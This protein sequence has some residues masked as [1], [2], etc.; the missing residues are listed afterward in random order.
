MIEL[1]YFGGKFLINHK[2]ISVV[3]PLSTGSSQIVLLSGLIYEVS[4]SLSNVND[5]IIEACLL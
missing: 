1:T 3:L 5:K 4:E 2:H